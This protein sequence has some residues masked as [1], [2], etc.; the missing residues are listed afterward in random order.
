M[1]LKIALCIRKSFQERNINILCSYID[2]AFQKKT[3]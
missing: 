3:C 1:L 2:E